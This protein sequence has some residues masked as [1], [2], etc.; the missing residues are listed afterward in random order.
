M[1]WKVRASRFQIGDGG[2]QNRACTKSSKVHGKDGQPIT[3]VIQWP[4]FGPY[5]LAR[6]NAA[7]KELRPGGVRVVGMETAT[8]DDTY[9][10]QLETG[11]TAFERCVVLSGKVYERSSSVDIWRG[12]YSVLDR[13]NPHAVAI[14]GYSS[15]DALSA[16]AWCK[17]HR[18]GAIL[19]SASKYDDAARQ[20][21]REWL[22]GRFVRRFDSALCSGTPQRTYLEGFG[23]KPEQ[24]HEGA[25]VIDNDYFRRGAEQAR[26]SPAS[27]RSLAGLESTEPFF[28]VSARFIQCKNLD[29]L[30]QAYA[31]Y[32]SRF[33]LSSGGRPWRLV[34]VGD[35]P[36]REALENL[37][38]S[39]R[40]QGVSFPGFVQIENLPIYYGLASA[41]ILP[42][43]KDTWGLVVN[44][45][46][47]AGLPVLVSNRCGC[48]KDLVSE[49][50]NGFTFPSN[51]MA[52]LSDL[53]M[54]VSFGGVDLESLGA[55][56]RIRIK[57]WGLDR[58]ARGLYG[59]LQLSLQK[60]DLRRFG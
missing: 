36:E 3:L 23:M 51:D 45:A 18:R 2:V 58:F 27:Y 59:A 49:G 26:R 43:H 60:L 24:I 57:E 13:I 56:S 9:A 54:R 44:E 4:R 7:F 50:V 11:A 21:W 22:K 12:I 38:T 52:Y 37:I 5:H 25:G 46:M 41:F 19:M 20:A 1:F 47:A 6:L 30:L 39:Q 17:V 40:I 55:A 31:Q 8:L 33:G 48:A 32:R 53:M 35:G 10:W 14:C 16:L 34:I 42:S 15:C 29:G 28:L